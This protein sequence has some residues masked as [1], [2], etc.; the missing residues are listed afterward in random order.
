MALKDDVTSD[1]AGIISQPWSLRDGTIVPSTEDVALAGGGV[2]L[3]VTILYADLA[4]STE[5]VL[6][7][8]RRVAAKVIKCFLAASSR[9]I[10]AFGGDIRSFDGDRVMGIYI[11]GS[12]NS[13]AAKTAL[14][15]KWAFDNIVKPKLETAYPSLANGSYKLGYGIGIDTSTVLAV[16]GGIRGS[17]DLVWVGRAPNVA[18][19]LS[20]L[21]EAPYRTYITADVYK[22]LSGET[23]YTTKNGQ[24]VDMWES[25]SWTQLPGFSLYRSSYHWGL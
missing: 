5:L 19:K 3:D 23:K 13:N 24:Q 15:I 22:M 11:G 9:I 21:R 14:K 8:D 6:E 4:D 17:N 16:R 25:R 7:Q 10:R 12:K 2:N 1:V 20:T 18:A